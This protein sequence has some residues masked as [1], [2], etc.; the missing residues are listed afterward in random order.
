MSEQVIELASDCALCS[1]ARRRCDELRDVN[2]ALARE[3]QQLQ[4]DLTAA[5]RVIEEVH[6]ALA[7]K[8]GDHLTLVAKRTHDELRKLRDAGAGSALWWDILAA[9]D[10]AIAEAKS[11]R[12]QLRE[13][14]ADLEEARAMLRGIDEAVG[15]VREGETLV[16]AV[17]RAVRIDERRLGSDERACPGCGDV[18]VEGSSPYVAGQ[19]ELYCCTCHS[20]YEIGTM[21]ELKFPTDSSSSEESTMGELKANGCGH[22][23]DAGGDESLSGDQATSA[24]RR[25]AAAKA[26]REACESRGGILA[27]ER[28]A[29]RQ[30]LD[31][32]ERRASERV[33][34]DGIV[35]GL[36]RATL[37]VRERCG[38]SREADLVNAF[39][40]AAAEVG[41]SVEPAMSAADVEAHASHEQLRGAEVRELREERDRLRAELTA[42]VEALARR[43]EEI[44]AI[45]QEHD[46]LVDRATA[47]RVDRDGAY[48]RG[49]EEMRKRADAHCADVAKSRQLIGLHD[50]A[51]ELLAAHYAISSLPIANA[52]TVSSGGTGE[53]DPVERGVET[54]GAGESVAR[55]SGASTRATCSEPNEEAAVDY[56]SSSWIP[57]CT[58]SAG[59]SGD[60][61]A[62]KP[63]GVEA[64]R[65]ARTCGKP[66]VVCEVRRSA[67]PESDAA[68]EIERLRAETSKLRAQRAEAI[69]R[70]TDLRKKLESTRAEIA[71][72]QRATAMYT[73]EGASRVMHH[74]REENEAW[75]GRY[76]SV[77]SEVASQADQL[78]AWR[79][80][81]GC[82]SPDAA[83]QRIDQLVADLALARENRAHFAEVASERREKL[84]E[85]PPQWREHFDEERKPRVGDI[86]LHCWDR[87]EEPAIVRRVRSDGSLDLWTTDEKMPFAFGATKH[88]PM[89]PNEPRLNNTWRFRD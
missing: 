23:G 74:M 78:A 31:A 83:K 36:R 70:A 13:V 25:I 2:A 44:E 57:L 4:I 11:L 89:K 6:S 62:R 75:C 71:Q 15:G 59:H 47:L 14:Q 85:Q 1:E 72:W 12:E 43:E 80:A 49:Q 21:R 3:G 10:A 40:R 34:A 54:A 45:K 22:C 33:Y 79:T 9:R 58:E 69:D 77:V 46:A 19:R 17:R 16:D 48:R 60:H 27:M 87:V 56:G 24:Q 82:D 41:G 20:R 84:R 38:G 64:A 42:T 32:G 55:E 35:D 53:V 66:D 26:L 28:N 30:G 5:K 52:P 8:P 63:D 61:V 86:V 18:L 39:D 51:R 68:V 65:W 67:K 73:A 81:T 29:Y 37:I 7:T 50:E 76:N 88:E